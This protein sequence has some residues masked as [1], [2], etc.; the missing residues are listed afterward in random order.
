MGRCG[1]LVAEYFNF[2]WWLGIVH[3]VSDRCAFVVWCVRVSE[4]CFFLLRN[5]SKKKGFFILSP[6]CPQSKLHKPPNLCKL[7]LP[8]PKIVVQHQNFGIWII[9][10]GGGNEAV[11]GCVCVCVCGQDKF[12]V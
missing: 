12:G 2:E 9:F 1:L 11:G 3:F 10:F 5:E 7:L 8:T 4:N 6:T